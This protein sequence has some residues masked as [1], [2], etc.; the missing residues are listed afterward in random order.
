MYSGEN[1]TENKQIHI[2]YEVRTSNCNRKKESTMRQTQRG[3][4][5]YFRKLFSVVAPVEEVLEQKIDCFGI[6]QL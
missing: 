1:Q 6:L 3:H 4:G 5:I 2:Y